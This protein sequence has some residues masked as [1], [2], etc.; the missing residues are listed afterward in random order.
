MAALGLA[1]GLLE[2]CNSSSSDRTAGGTTTSAA[3][4]AG[5]PITSLRIPFLADMG[6]P[7]PD[8]F[9]AAEGLMVTLACYDSLVRYT[10]RPPGVPLSYQQ[11]SQRISP[12]LATAWDISPDGLTYT[13]HLRPGVVF[14]DGSP[15]NAQA[16]QQCFDR[17]GKV[18][19]GPAYQ[20]APVASTAAPDPLT[21]VVTLKH[22]VDPFLDYMACPYGPK[23]ISPTAIA[24][25]QANGDLA[26][27]WLTTKEAGTGP[28]QIVEWVSNDHYTLQAF[29]QYWG[30]KPEAQ[31]IT[32]PIVPDVQTQ[33]LQF[34]GGQLDIITKGLPIQDVEQY[35]K[36]RN[37][38]VK[39]FPCSLSTAFYFNPT[40]G[41]IFS[42]P[43][44][45][46]AA[47]AAINKSL[48]VKSTFVDT[49]TTATQFFP[50]GCFPD[51]EVADNAPYNPATL[52]KMVSSL[53]SKKVDLAYGE[54]GGAINRL[55]A[56]LVQTEWQ[57]EGLQVTVR[58][59]TTDVEYALYNTP[60]SQR[61]DI[62]LDLYGGDTIHVDT[63]LRIIFRT[64][65]APLNWFDYSYPQ[66]DM[67]MDQASEATTQSEVIR[68]YAE[69]ASV[70]RDANILE[71]LS[72]DADVI[73]YRAGITGIV[74]D[75]M[76]LQMI[77][78][79]DLKSVP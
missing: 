70:Y 4:V 16:W 64:G 59:I 78:L 13:F 11:P 23:V 74:H 18:N 62:M 21:F 63:M 61:P 28:Y 19:Q 1:P 5:K 2:A 49:A 14:H 33:E 41:R 38:G 36:N 7:D 46:A 51:G 43:T 75:P 68:L 9:Y 48:V 31:T 12:A 54:D 39:V 10:P 55:L 34:R 76:S 57:A 67:L 35:A 30:T 79:E 42:D 24:A 53:P 72:N 25:H 15:M 44:L 20:V 3:P 32:I 60:D 17:R 65:A 77:R 69:A 56:E 40:K 58:G 71:N 66:G 45:R 29:P 37:Y 50:G 47:K 52:S 22:P 26:Q 6:T 8:I 73:V 27:G